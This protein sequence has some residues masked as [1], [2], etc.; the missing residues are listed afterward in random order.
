MSENAD[1]ARLYCS[2]AGRTLRIR[3]EELSRFALAAKR[4]RIDE[5]TDA[6]A[7]LFAMIREYPGNRS[8][9]RLELGGREIAALDPDPERQGAWGWAE[10]PVPEGALSSGVNEFVFRAESPGMNSWTLAVSCERPRG[11]SRKSLDGGG[12]WPQGML[13]GYD[14][15]LSGEYV[16]RLRVDPAK[17]PD[18]PRRPRFVCESPDHP[19]LAAM[20]AEFGLEKLARG[21]KTD[22]ERAQR[23]MSWWVG[24]W[25]YEKNC[26]PIYAPWDPFTVIA[27]KTASWG[28]GYEK[29]LAYCVH[30][31][32]CLTL[33][34]RAAGL[35][36]RSIVTDS[37]DPQGTGGHYLTE[38]WAGELDR[39]VVLDPHF[40]ATLTLDGEPAPAVE[41]QTACEA[42]ECSRLGFV[43]GKSYGGNPRCKEKWLE[44][45][46]AG[47]GFWEL[48]WYERGDMAS[49][50]ELIPPE[51]GCSVYHESCFLWLDTPRTPHRP[52]FPHWTRDRAALL[53]APK[54]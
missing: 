41:F 54:T 35:R 48:G 15:T 28:A 18:R 25:T 32:S 31:A 26:G 45:W 34:L 3:G 46:L 39:W 36:A 14:C 4:F 27:W 17:K 16:A 8:A 22:L 40:D 19:R 13:L 9:L 24:S 51:H 20:R 1:T 44:R 21:A 7:S 37:E 6:C 30:S 10:L 11:D 38:L 2:D 49:H 5:G 23:I 43:P 53:A 33:L 50:P 52:Y 47:R 29:P 12:S 42:G